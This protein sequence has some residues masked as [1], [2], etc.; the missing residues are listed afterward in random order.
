MNTLVMEGYVGKT[1]NL[2]KVEKIFEEIKKEVTS[3]GDDRVAQ[4][5]QAMQLNLTWDK[6]FR[7]VEKLFE[8]EF[9]FKKFQLISKSN[10][11]A[12]AFTMISSKFTKVN[13]SKMPE[14]PTKHGKRYYDASQQY[15]CSVWIYSSLFVDLTPGEIVAIILQ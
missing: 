10:V 8:K 11:V 13:I 2:A 6:R 9:G 12:N 3:V 4:Y 1:P 15:M 14:L 7:L 5:K